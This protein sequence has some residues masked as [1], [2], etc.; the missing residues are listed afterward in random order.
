MDERRTIV[1]PDQVTKKGRKPFRLGIKCPVCGN[2]M[3]LRDFELSSAPD[4]NNF[5]L[6]CDECLTRVCVVTIAK[7]E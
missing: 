7:K 4:G 6:E 1:L 5:T 2:I 3:R